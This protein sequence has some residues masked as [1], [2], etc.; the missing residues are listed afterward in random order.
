M[1]RERAHAAARTSWFD[2][3]RGLRAEILRQAHPPRTAYFSYT[4][5]NLGKP[6]AWPYVVYFDFVRQRKRITGTDLLE[7]SIAQRTVIDGVDTPTYACTW[8]NITTIRLRGDEQREV[9]ALEFVGRDPDG[10]E[11][12]FHPPAWVN[13]HYNLFDARARHAF[14]SLGLTL[15]EPA[16]HLLEYSV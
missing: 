10:L 14:A 6:G 9:Y 15:R 8:H 1:P 3:D 5:L 13:I 4:V 2:F 7:I 16:A 11:T 12:A